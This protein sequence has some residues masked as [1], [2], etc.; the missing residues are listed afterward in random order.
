MSIKTAIKA[1]IEAVTAVLTAGMTVYYGIAP[2]RAALP[3]IILNRVTGSAFGYDQGGREAWN[4]E[5]FQVDLYHSDDE[6][7]ETIRNAIIAALHGQGPAAWSG[8]TVLS[9]LVADSRDLTAL[10]DEGG[11]Q[12]TIR[13][14]FDLSVKYVP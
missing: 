12:G 1:K 14:S 5:T 9:C 6:S 8:M 10:E 3:Y 4:K 11:E 7:C 2:Q 13:Q